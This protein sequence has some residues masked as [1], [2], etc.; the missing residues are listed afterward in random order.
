MNQKLLVLLPGHPTCLPRLAVAASYR[1]READIPKR[2]AVGPDNSRS[3]NSQSANTRLSHLASEVHEVEKPPC[4]MKRLKYGILSNLPACPPEQKASYRKPDFTGSTVAVPKTQSS[5]S[6]GHSVWSAGSRWD[7][8]E[9]HPA[10][11]D[12]RELG[13]ADFHPKGLAGTGCAAEWVENDAS[14]RCQWFWSPAKRYTA[15]Q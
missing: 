12:R 14:V 15:E 8:G 11:V 9:K 3:A 4:I 6:L 7:E 1:H 10:R 5:F 13:L 2:P